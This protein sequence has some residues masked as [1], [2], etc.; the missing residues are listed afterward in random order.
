M[1]KAIIPACLAQRAKAPAPAPQP[2]PA[3]P[4]LS[5]A[6]NETYIQ[7]TRTVERLHRRFLDVLPRSRALVSTTSMPFRR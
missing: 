1:D 7:L 6:A 4:A 3:A 5:E 2:S